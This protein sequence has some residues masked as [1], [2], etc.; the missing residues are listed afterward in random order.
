M[1]KK[2][3]LNEVQKV[4]SK[5]ILGVMK[6]TKLTAEDCKTLVRYMNMRDEIIQQLSGGK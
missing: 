6:G 2:A 1:S 4:L 3:N 5:I